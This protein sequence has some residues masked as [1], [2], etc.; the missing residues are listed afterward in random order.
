[1]GWGGGVQMGQGEQTGRGGSAQLC[2]LN[3]VREIR[4]GSLWHFHWVFLGRD[5]AFH[6]EQK[7]DL[8]VKVLS[9]HLSSTSPRWLQRLMDILLLLVPTWCYRLGLPGPL[10]PSQ[11][12]LSVPQ[13]VES[14][15]GGGGGEGCATGG[16]RLLL[17]FTNGR[18][19]DPNQNN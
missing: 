4:T 14:E 16:N 18:I 17:P 13:R 15:G 6:S 11:P 3:R 5:V 19:S 2:C 1:M 9:E 10:P 8:F 12:C 7:A